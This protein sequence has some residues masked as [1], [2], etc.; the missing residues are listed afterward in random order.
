MTS[1]GTD[2]LLQDQSHITETGFKCSWWSFPISVTRWSVA[3]C[4]SSQWGGP[5]W[6]SAPT[7]PRQD[8]Q[9]DWHICAL[10][11]KFSVLWSF[12]AR[13]EVSLCPLLQLFPPTV[14]DWTVL[15]AVVVSIGGFALLVLLIIGIVFCYRRRKEKRKANTLST[16]GNIFVVLADSQKISV[17]T[18]ADTEKLLL[19]K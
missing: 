3:A 8:P 14:P 16:A 11:S 18:L 5:S 12:D 10:L 19:W 6:F 7:H 17:V 2:I 1:S 15:I 13:N 9:S 4:L